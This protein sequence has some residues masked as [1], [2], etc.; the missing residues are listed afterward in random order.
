MMVEK[1]FGKIWPDEFVEF[2]ELLEA[3]K[4]VEL[5]KAVI[6]DGDEELDASDRINTIWT[7]SIA[8]PILIPLNELKPEKQS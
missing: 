2:W 7:L 3:E 5:F 6:T 1:L 4:F 8:K